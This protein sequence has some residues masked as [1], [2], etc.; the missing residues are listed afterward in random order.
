MK[1]LRLSTQTISELRLQANRAEEHGNRLERALNRAQSELL[2]RDQEITELRLQVQ[3]DECSQDCEGA[4]EME[5]HKALATARET[6]E[7]L[8]VSMKDIS[9]QELSPACPCTCLVMS[10]CGLTISYIHVL[11]HKRL[12]TIYKVLQFFYSKGLVAQK[13][14]LS[15]KYQ[16][17]L[18]ESNRE[19]QRLAEV[20][21]VEVS[22]LM[23]QLH[24]QTD[25][26]FFKL[27]EAAL[28]A[29]N[30][31]CP[32]LPTDKHLARLQVR[33]GV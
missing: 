29:V 14:R 27:K 6:I 21:K 11:I 2:K 15:E 3:G 33:H 17:L 23:N 16:K 26:T 12:S 25:S 4:V 19:L 13:E 24:S 28:D 5:S 18:Q 31:P 20:H 10:T 32:E 30:V 1:N 22:S 8:R 7:Q 9:G